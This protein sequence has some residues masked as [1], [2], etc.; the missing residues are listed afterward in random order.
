MRATPAATQGPSLSAPRVSTFHVTAAPPI[1]SAPR[2]SVYRVPRVCAL[3]IR[4][5]GKTRWSGNRDY[6]G[7]GRE[8]SVDGTSHLVLL[9]KY[10]CEAEH[11]SEWYLQ[12]D[13][14]SAFILH[15]SCAGARASFVVSWGI[16]KTKQNQ[17]TLKR[18][19]RAG[20]RCALT[21][22]EHPLSRVRPRALMCSC[23]PTGPLCA[24]R[25]RPRASGSSPAR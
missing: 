11:S 4:T 6:W 14:E 15:S 20:Q 13:F 7:H 2:P 24:R 9:S 17:N 18:H 10:R 22:R 25:W 19:R 12:F 21:D 5:S 23:R 3:S 16:F 1:L 8:I